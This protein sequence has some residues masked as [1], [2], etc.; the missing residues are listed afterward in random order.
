M[1][2]REF[3]RI[4]GRMIV[5]P[6]AKPGEPRRGPDDAGRAEQHEADAPSPLGDDQQGDRRR[7]HAADARSEKHHAVG[8]AP[9]VDRKPLRETA[10]DVRKRTR[11]TG[12]EQKT[13]C[14]KRQEPSRRC[15]QHRER[16]P[17]QHDT[18]QHAARPDDVAQPSRRNLEQRIRQG[19]GAEDDAHLQHGEVQVVDDVRRRG[20]NADAIQVCND[21]EEK[22]EAEYARTDSGWR[23]GRRF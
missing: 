23:H 2:P 15:R 13:D 1:N 10:R 16:R 4:H 12:A 8:A 3:L 7:Q 18:R 19:E 14:D 22:R 21:R 5:G 9:F 6:V 20:G 11:L 17:P